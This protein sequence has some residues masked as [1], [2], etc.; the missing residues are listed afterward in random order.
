MNCFPILLSIRDL[1]SKH[2]KVIT[3]STEHIGSDDL[4]EYYLG[5][6]PEEITWV[7]EEHLSICSS[8]NAKAIHVNAWV[9]ATTGMTA[10][11]HHE[12]TVASA[13][14]VEA[15]I[16]T[17]LKKKAVDTSNDW[18]EQLAKWTEV[19]AKKKA[20]VAVALIQSATSKA[21]DIVEKGMEEMLTS[22]PRMKLQVI[23]GR[24]N[25]ILSQRTRSTSKHRKID[26]DSSLEDDNATIIARQKSTEEGEKMNIKVELRY[27]GFNEPLVALISSSGAD[28]LIEKAI[29]ED[30]SFFVAEFKNCPIEEYYII[31]EPKR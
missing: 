16:L 1:Y 21:I 4:V 28:V 3:M 11:A 2:R 5:T 8:C 19:W 9:G 26:G 7:I 24:S 23:D 10:V 31:V 22:N 15:K 14:K 30:D 18:S 17:A 25:I 6:L 29:K 27:P 20:A 12:A 13:K